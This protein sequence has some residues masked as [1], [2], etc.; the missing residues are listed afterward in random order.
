MTETEIKEEDT[1][2]TILRL[3]TGEDVICEF[4]GLTKKTFMMF[5]PMIIEYV[6]DRETGKI[7]MVMT[8]WVPVYLVKQNRA[9]MMYTE[10]ITSFAPTDSLTEYYL[11]KINGTDVTDQV[12]TNEDQ[13]RERDY[14][15]KLKEEHKLH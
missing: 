7:I 6:R 10:M 8:P 12:P 11:N 13:Q 3:R 4:Q 14:V 5:N 2:I 9:E 1:N 15:S